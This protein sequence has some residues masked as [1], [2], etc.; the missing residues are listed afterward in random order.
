M[1]GR[2]SCFLAMALVLAMALPTRA[3][4][5]TV[6][7]IG[8]GQVG[9]ALGQRFGEL[10][11][12]VVYGSRAPDREVVARLVALSGPAARAT[13][14]RAAVQGADIV[15][16]AVPWNVVEDVARR[17]GDLS[18][19]IV[20]D[21]TN[22]RSIAGDGLRDYAFEGSNAERIQA[23]VPRALVVKAF[24]TLGADTM[25]DPSIRG[26]A[27]TIPLVGDDT[28]AKQ[29]LASLIEAMGLEAVDVG[30]LRYARVIEGL[31][32]LRTNAGQLGGRRINYHLPLEAP[33]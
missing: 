27:V 5:E 20:V 1:N 26:G 3:S 12:S 16:L 30:P 9:S 18:G 33:P 10:G 8:T 32:Y 23:I 15:I 7:I 2:S 28:G 17:L 14:Q 19:Q 25:M 24:S 11:Y 21:P 31:H 13:T 6:A 29:T 22:P 4:T